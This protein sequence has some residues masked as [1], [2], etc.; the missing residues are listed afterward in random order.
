[1]RPELAAETQ[2]VLARHLD[3][4]LSAWPSTTILNL[5]VIRKATSALIAAVPDAQG[6]GVYLDNSLVSFPFEPESDR[7]GG[8]TLIDHSLDFFVISSFAVLERIAS[9]AGEATPRRLGFALRALLRMAWAFA[10]C[11]EELSALLSYQFLGQGEV[12]PSLHERADRVF[13]AHRESYREQ[14]ARDLENVSEAL[15]RSP[16]PEPTNETFL[17]VAA[18]HLSSLCRGCKP[19][20]RRQVATSQ[21]H[22]TANRLGLSPFE[23]LYLGR[24]LWRTTQDLA[25]S[26][27]ET[28]QRLTR[29]LTV[30][31]TGY[32]ASSSSLAELVT[33]ALNYLRQFN[34]SS[35]H[36]ELDF[37]AN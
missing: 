19:E 35:P 24:I 30:G 2:A 37:V 20:T 15:A 7:Y 27:P 21:L 36:P 6:D 9:Q 5:E 4:F 14:M 12:V 18:R 11:E 31:P 1:L 3:L 28:W 10:S 26:K 32:N 34:A 23:E 16:A 29:S 13:E 8:E 25:S 22:M 17:A 33:S